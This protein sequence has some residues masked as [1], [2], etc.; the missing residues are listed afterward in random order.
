MG[1]RTALLVALALAAGANVAG[2]TGGAA[3][4]QAATL[5]A[6]SSNWAGYA[7]RRTGVRFRRVS[8][9]WTVPAVD[10]SSGARASS[11]NWLGLGGYS[12][13]SPALEQLGTESDC[14]AGARASYSAW[15][16]V[17]PAAAT[18]ARLTIRPG[19]VIAASVTVTGHRVTMT[20]ADTTRGTRA[21]RTV[22]AAAVDVSSAEWIVE[23]PSLCAGSS[24]SDASCRQTAL[25]DFGAT[26][27][28]AARATTTGGHAGTILDGAWNAIAIALSQGPAQRGPGLLP[29][30]DG[31]GRAAEEGDAAGGATPGTLAAT[32]D[33]FTVTYG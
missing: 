6:T 17:V 14:S 32:G 13:T 11:A 2:A 5:H 1:R 3:G 16:E 33:A 18:S 27:F 19:D 20:L 12:T 23:A 7:A 21:S 15:F 30:G 26:G 4:A 25:A 28:T 29:G 9:R 31:P 22:T 24:A 10:C 8:G